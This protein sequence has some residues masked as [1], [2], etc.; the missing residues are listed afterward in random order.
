[1]YMTKVPLC[2][3]VTSFM[4]MADKNE[5][6]RG[7]TTLVWHRSTEMEVDIHS[8]NANGPDLENTPRKLE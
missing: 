8:S 7:N 3:M 2:G 6:N 4:G 5:H 1:M